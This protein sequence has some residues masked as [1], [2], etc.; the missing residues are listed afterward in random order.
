MATTAFAVTPWS[1]AQR[2]AMMATRIP[3]TLAPALAVSLFAVTAYDAKTCSMVMRAL[4]AA[5]TPTMMN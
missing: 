2:L 5:M 4:K 3:T 1:K